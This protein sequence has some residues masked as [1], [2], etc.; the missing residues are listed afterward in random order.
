M[1]SGNSGR[2]TNLEDYD[3]T[4]SGMKERILVVNDDD[5]I[6]EI[7]CSMLTA[8]GYLCREAT[9]GLN[10]L[11][12]LLESEEFDLIVTDLMNDELG[13]MGLLERTKVYPNTPVVMVAAMND[14]SVVLAAIRNGAYDYLPMPFEREQLLAM[15]HRALDNRRL[16]VDSLKYQMEL[17][18]V[19]DIRN[20]QLQKTSASLEHSYDIALKGFG[21][22]LAL[23]DAKTAEHS[24]R[25]AAFTIG[26]RRAMGLPKDQIAVIARGAFLHDIG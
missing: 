6:R 15:V 13:G 8:A 2:V 4:L 9:G 26:I 12:L 19:V 16:K 10:A 7:I 23:R 18:R 5:P 17:Q 3:A 21:D 11:A 1:H 24:K 25:V 22:A 14:I 20:E